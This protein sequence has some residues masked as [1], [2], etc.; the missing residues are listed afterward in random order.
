LIIDLA[1]NEEHED[2]KE[3]LLEHGADISLIV[4]RPKASAQSSI[5]LD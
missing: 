2:C 3:L 4:P 1:V 5:K